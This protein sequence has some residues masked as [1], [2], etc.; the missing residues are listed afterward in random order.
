MWDVFVKSV[1]WAKESAA[2]P[3]FRT[4][5][6]W[7]GEWVGGCWAGGGV[8]NAENTC[9]TALSTQRLVQHSM[10]RAAPQPPPPPHQPPAHAERPYLRRCRA[11]GPPAAPPCA[12]GWPAAAGAPA[13]KY[14][15][16]EGG[17]KQLAVRGGKD[18]GCTQ[19]ISRAVQP[20]WRYSRAVRCVPRPARCGRGWRPP[21]AG[22]AGCRW[23][24]CGRR[25]PDKVG[26]WAGGFV[27]VNSEQ[28]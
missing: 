16:A 23:T 2:A 6:W 1:E 4:T 5:L 27:A 12:C 25:P 17:R 18:T 14:K 19:H 13:N 8:N 11:S 24:S 10:Q 22:A 28:A 26:C 15:G 21:G 7:V 20:L 3:L 9:K